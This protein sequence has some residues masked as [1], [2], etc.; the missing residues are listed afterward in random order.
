[1]KRRARNRPRFVV[2]LTTVR[3]LGVFLDD[4]AEVSAKVVDRLAEQFGVGE[5]RGRRRTASGRAA[6]WSRCG[7]CED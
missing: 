7:S 4:P 3:L 1:M 5:C 6:G 2:R